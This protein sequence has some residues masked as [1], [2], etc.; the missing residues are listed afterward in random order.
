MGNL[1]GNLKSQAPSELNLTWPKGDGISADGCQVRLCNQGLGSRGL[2]YR[3]LG[4]RA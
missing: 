3:G 1:A 4:Y 2:Q